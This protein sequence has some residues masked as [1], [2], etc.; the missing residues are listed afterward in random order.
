MRKRDGSFPQQNRPPT[1]DFPDKRGL[2]TLLHPEP[3]LLTYTH[4]QPDV[5][6]MKFPVTRCFSWSAKPPPSC[7]RLRPPPYSRYP[8]REPGGRRATLAPLLGI[9]AFRI[10]LHNLTRGNIFLAPPLP[11]PHEVQGVRGS[12]LCV[13]KAIPGKETVKPPPG[14]ST[15][16]TVWHQCG[17]DKSQNAGTMAGFQKTCGDPNPNGLSWQ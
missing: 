15:G 6:R 2:A 17:L 4:G 1:T 10:D 13:T 5:I 14:R 16:N 9:P 11:R 7:H 8:S 3:L 12:D